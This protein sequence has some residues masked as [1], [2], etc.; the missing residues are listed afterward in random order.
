MIRITG[1][2]YLGR[3]LLTPETD[4]TKPTMDRVREGVFNALQADIY[5][6]TV[7]DLFSGSGSYGFESLS[8][9]AKSVSFVDCSLEAIKALKENIS[10]LKEEKNT[11]THQMDYVSYLNSNNKQFDIIFVDPPYKAYSYNEIVDLLLKSNS[12]SDN[13][14]IVLESEDDLLLDESPFRKVKKYKYGLAKVYILRK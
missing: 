8:R 12:L 13:G 7:L 11:S 9:G 14:I 3:K 10:L 5:D 6:A 1:G 2:K 4:K